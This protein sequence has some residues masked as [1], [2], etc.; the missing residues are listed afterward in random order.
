MVWYMFIDEHISFDFTEMVWNLL[1]I[2]NLSFIEEKSYNMNRKF[3]LLL[4]SFYV[5]LDTSLKDRSYRYSN[6]T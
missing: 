2:A 3:D 5:I 1:K 4:F 6:E